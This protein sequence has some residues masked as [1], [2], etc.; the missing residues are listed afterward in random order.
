MENITE[1]KA[2]LCESVSSFERRL[3]EAESNCESLKETVNLLREQKG[4]LESEMES[5]RDSNHSAENE[6]KVC[7]VFGG[8]CYRRTIQ[9]P[10]KKINYSGVKTLSNKYCK[11]WVQTCNSHIFLLPK[12]CKTN[13]PI[14]SFT[15]FVYTEHSSYTQRV[16]NLRI[17][18]AHICLVSEIANEH[19]IL[20]VK[21]KIKTTNTLA[22]Y[23]TL[24]VTS[25]KCLMMFYI[26]QPFTW[27]DSD[28]LTVPR[29]IYCK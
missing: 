22:V 25:R 16:R 23:P 6:A 20:Q 26:C 1:E 28:F 18:A 27:N 24:S 13:K 12:A 2:T 4:A 21:Q 5:L 3:A 14:K 9:F 8:S 17:D 7:Y 10:E 15:V 29:N 11:K 19:D